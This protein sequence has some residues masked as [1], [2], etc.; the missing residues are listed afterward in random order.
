[1]GVDDASRAVKASGR[2]RPAEAGLAPG[3]RCDRWGAGRE[4][5]LSVVRFESADVGATRTLCDYCRSVVF[6]AFIET[7]EGFV[8]PAD[9]P[10]A[11]MR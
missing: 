5:R 10:P 11:A 1:L 7:D 9:E 6:E 4:A 8:D 3:H 2:F